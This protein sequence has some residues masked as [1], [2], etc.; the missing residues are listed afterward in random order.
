MYKNIETKISTELYAWSFLARR[1]LNFLF[2]QLDEEV[3]EALWPAC[4]VYC[5][6]PADLEETFFFPFFLHIARTSLAV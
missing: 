6:S 3:L 1:L 5:V 4:R 2:F